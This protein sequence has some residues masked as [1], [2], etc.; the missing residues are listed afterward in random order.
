MNISLL[1]FN[2]ILQLCKIPRIAFKFKKN[3][4]LYTFILNKTAYLN[5]YDFQFTLSDRL[6]YLIN[7][8]N[9]ILRCSICGKPIIKHLNGVYPSKIPQTCGSSCKAK[10]MFSKK[11]NSHHIVCIKKLYQKLEQEE[12]VPLFSVQEFIEK[13]RP[14]QKLIYS[15]FKWKCKKCGGIFEDKFNLNFFNRHNHVAH[16][17]CR[18]C[19]PLSKNSGISKAEIEIYNFLKSIYDGE[20]IQKDRKTLTHNDYRNPFEI[21]IFLPQLKLGIE[22]NG[23]YWHGRRENKPN[24]NR[25]ADTHI[26]KTEIS[27]QKNIR[28]IHIW[29]HEWNS[30]KEYIKKFLIDIISNRLDYRKYIKNFNGKPALDRSKF[31]ATNIFKQHTIL[32]V[33][34][35]EL[36]TITV[37]RGKRKKTQVKYTVK[38]CGYLIL[39]EK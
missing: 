3:N 7:K 21:D 22:Y 15:K 4:L 39:K 10:G 13:Y 30:Q 2:Y 27:E 17:R 31:N 8:Y 28:L 6:W 11:S 23:L 9:D 36:K 1:L 19:Y 37:F 14:K 5:K 33:S 20:I 24:S 25:I 38:T 29:E 16:A 12:V 26:L 35:P 34:K 18:T 32:S